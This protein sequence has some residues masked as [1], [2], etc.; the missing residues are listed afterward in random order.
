MMLVSDRELRAGKY[1]K[2]LLS[3]DKGRIVEAVMSK[4]GLLYRVYRED[5]EEFLTDYPEGRGGWYWNSSR[6]RYA[7]EKIEIGEKGKEIVRVNPMFIALH[8]L[9]TRLYE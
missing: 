8:F 7:V 2:C 3:T 6:D 1:V 4:D 5:I 9:S